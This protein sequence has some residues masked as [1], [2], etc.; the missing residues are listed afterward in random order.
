MTDHTPASLGFRW[1]AEWEPHEA[2]WLAWPHNRDTWP[3]KLNRIVPVFVRLI[4][5]LSAYEPVHVL[6]GGSEVLA[7]AKSLAGHLPNVTLWDIETN[8][9]WIRDYGPTFLLHG[10]S[11]EAAMVD[12]QYNAW[13]GKYPPFDSDNA[14]ASQIARQL[15]VRRF[16][17]GLTLEG[18]AIEGNGDGTML[19]TTSC[20]LNP[21][22]NVTM[23]KHVVERYLSEFLCV[24]EVIW[25][26]DAKLAGDDTDGHVD[27]LV[28]FVAPTTVVIA[29][30]DDASDVNY[31][32]LLSIRKQVEAIRIEQQPPEVIPLPMPQPVIDAGKRL[33][34]SYA[35]FYIANQVVIVPQFDAPADESAIATLESCFPNR[36]VIGLAARDLITGLGA[37]H[38]IT[39]QQPKPA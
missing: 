5:I 25:L 3:G 21:N 14:A 6:A 37:C 2:T 16:A 26:E 22:R 32:S 12:W 9:A 11:P 34:A 15:A 17:P 23:S 19:T 36:D 33:P 38:C 10:Q 29:T 28:R 4:E 18:G 20:L 30:E 39:Q 31:P 27:Q 8:D 24:R 7:Q 13:G 1:P 35:N